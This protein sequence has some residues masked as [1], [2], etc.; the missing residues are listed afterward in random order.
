ME[1]LRKRVRRKA[2]HSMR[3]GRVTRGWVVF[4]ALVSVSCG[5]PPLGVSLD[6][7]FEVLRQRN[8]SEGS[9][10]GVDYNPA[11]TTSGAEGTA[12]LTGSF[13]GY[14]CGDRLEPAFFRDGS[15]LIFRL[16]FVEEV[17]DPICLQSIVV[18]DYT[19]TF[20]AV[21]AGHY[22]LYAVHDYER[23]DSVR[24]FEVGNVT[25]R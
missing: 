16:E 25:I 17:A 19:A 23:A 12:T 11:F 4:L 3:C 18:S 6:G 24:R 7:T 5:D 14:G 10:P 15:E 2:R 21:P 8:P 13:W 22:A 1:F 20:D 9:Q